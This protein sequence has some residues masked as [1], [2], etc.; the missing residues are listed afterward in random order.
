M[1]FNHI[2]LILY[3]RY[4]LFWTFYLAILWNRSINYFL[5]IFLTP[6]IWMVLHMQAINK[7]NI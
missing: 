5:Q 4:G 7:S 3:I 2:L 1:Y 6:N